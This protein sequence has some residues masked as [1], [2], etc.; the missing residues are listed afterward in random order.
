[1]G[2]DPALRLGAPLLSPRLSG[3]LPALE[4]RGFPDPQAEMPRSLRFCY[5]WMEDTIEG[6]SR[7]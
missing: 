6:L 1:M 4:H 7:Q 3:Q 5:D 2:D